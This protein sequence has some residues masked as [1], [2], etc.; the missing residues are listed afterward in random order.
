M[1]KEQVLGQ[2]VVAFSGAMDLGSGTVVASRLQTLRSVLCSG[3]VVRPA[4]ADKGKPGDSHHGNVTGRVPIVT[5]GP[6]KGKRIV[7][8]TVLGHRSHPFPVPTHQPRT[9]ARGIPSSALDIVGARR[10]PGPGVGCS[11]Y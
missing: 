1:L 11:D 9:R 8:W 10:R 6:L 5:A 2:F 7:P 4:P 3:S